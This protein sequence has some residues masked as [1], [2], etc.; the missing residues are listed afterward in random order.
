[1]AK[2]KIVQKPAIKTKL[3]YDWL[4]CEKYINY[5]YNISY[6]R[7]NEWIQNQGQIHNGCFVYVNNEC[8]DNT[9]ITQFILD[10]F[11]DGN[12]EIELYVYW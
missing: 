10:E 9:G 3:Y 12:K 1:M 6:I 2:K 8:D 5:K 11:S 4:E 7:L